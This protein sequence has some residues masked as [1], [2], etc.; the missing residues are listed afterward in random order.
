[1]GL[2]AT[3]KKHK[4]P[5]S[6]IGSIVIILAMYGLFSYEADAYDTVDLSNYVPG[7]G[8]GGGGGGPSGDEEN[9][10]ED[11]TSGTLNEQESA[12]YNFSSGGWDAMATFILTWE[13]EPDNG[14]PTYE[15]EGDTFILEVI[16]PGSHRDSGEATN[17]HDQEGRIE[18]TFDIGEETIESEWNV[19]VTLDDAGEQSAFGQGT[20]V[21]FIDDSNSYTLEVII[22]YYLD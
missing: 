17:E 22:E 7:G 10:Y 4:K 21:V 14:V 9:T 16:G 1:M 8:G 20:G 19:T 2:D 12:M 15:N 18:L 13:D 3:I 6:L 5:I 11:S